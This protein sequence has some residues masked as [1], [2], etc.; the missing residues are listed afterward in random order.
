MI[1][2]ELEQRQRLIELLQ[3][4]GCQCEDQHD[5]PE[6]ATS[7]NCLAGAAL[8]DLELME[9]NAKT[10][11]DYGIARDEE[12]RKERA[13]FVEVSNKAEADAYKVKCYECW[14]KCL[15][16]DEDSDSLTAYV[17]RR[18]LKSASVCS[19][20]VLSDPSVF[21]PEEIAE[22]AGMARED[23]ENGDIISLDEFGDALKKRLED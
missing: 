2:L 23:L 22:A 8:H 16:N 11:M 7:L 21:D 20:M 3:A 17:A 4:E 5:D 6:D 19:K 10:A 14:L 13:E 18:R 15:A 9:R 12:L 1:H